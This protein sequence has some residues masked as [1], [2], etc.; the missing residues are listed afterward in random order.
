MDWMRGDLTSG[1]DLDAAVAGMA[2]SC[3]ARA[4]SA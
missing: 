3:I 2:E 4:G 1:D